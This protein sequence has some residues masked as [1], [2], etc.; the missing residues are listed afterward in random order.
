MRALRELPTLGLLFCIATIPV[1]AY[2]ALVVSVHD[3][4]SLRIKRHERHK[5]QERTERIRLAGVDAP[6]LEQ[7]FGFAA[8]SVT[9]RLTLGQTVTI[10]DRG[11]DRY[12][13]IVADVTNRQGINVNQTLVKTGMAWWY[14]EFAPHDHTLERLQIS[15]QRKRLGLWAHP[16]SEPPWVYRRTA[17]HEN[18]GLR[19][20]ERNS[21]FR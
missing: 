7:P 3:G 15:A 1:H 9:E 12:G 5:E 14:Q 8:R 17:A 19:T 4:D 11:Y 2:K 10:H 6:E 18:E 16:G 20:A 13:R 21:S